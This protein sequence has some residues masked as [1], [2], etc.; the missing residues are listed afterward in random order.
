MRSGQIIATND[1]LIRELIKDENYRINEDGSIESK[2][3][4]KEWR[5]LKLKVNSSGYRELQYKGKYLRLQRIVY[6][7]FKSLQS[8]LVINH[9]DGKIK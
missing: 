3:I 5:T 6:A 8:D 9:I 7:R 1:D 4:R 2:K